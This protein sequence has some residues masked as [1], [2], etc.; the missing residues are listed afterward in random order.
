MAS[1]AQKTQVAVINSRLF[2]NENIATSANSSIGLLSTGAY[3]ASSSTPYIS[4]ATTVKEASELIATKLHVL[5]TTFAPTTYVDQKV[6]D[7]INSAPGILDTLGEIAASLGNDA[8]LSVTLVSTISAETGR[9]TLSEQAL[10]TALISESA[11]AVSSEETLSSIIASETSRAISVEESLSTIIASETSYAR[12]QEQLLST[13]IASESAR[14]ISQEQY[15]STTLHVEIQRALQDDENVSTIFSQEVLR[16]T[17][18]ESVLSTSIVTER[19]RATGAEETLSTIVASEIA[20]AISAEES[21]SSAVVSEISRATA[22]ETTI[23]ENLSTVQR[24]YINKDG[25]VKMTANLDMSGSKIVNLSSSPVDS[26]DAVSLGYYK[27][28]ATLNYEGTISVAPYTINSVLNPTNLDLITSSAGAILRVMG[29]TSSQNTGTVVY[30]VLSTTSTVTANN[31]GEYRRIVYPSLNTTNILNDAGILDLSANN[32]D[33]SGSSY[34]NPYDLTTSGNDLRTKYPAYAIFRI[35]L[36]SRSRFYIY[37]D[38]NTGSMI[39]IRMDPGDIFEFGGNG[40]YFRIIYRAAIDAATGGSFNFD[41]ANRPNFTNYV[42]QNAFY[43]QFTTGGTITANFR[44]IVVVKNS[45]L[46]LKT[47]NSTQWEHIDT[48]DPY[49]QGTKNRIQIVGNGP[50]ISDYIIDIAPDYI[51]Q[52][53]IRTVGDI[54]SGNW[55][56]NPIAAGRG[57]TGQT[58]YSNGDILYGDMGTL[59]KL[60]IG[61]NQKVIK[62]INGK[63]SWQDNTTQ[64]IIMTTNINGPSKL[65]ATLE[66]LS[67][68]V[69]VETTR[70]TTVETTLSTTIVNQISSII[71][72][73]PQALD[74]LNEIAIALGNDPNLSATLIS[75]I[76]GETARATSAEGTLTANLSFEISRASAAEGFISTFLISTITAERERA[77]AAEAS[78][79]TA[80]NSNNDTEM[81]RAVA[82]E[83]GLSTSIAEEIARA[84]AAESGLDTDI[85]NEIARATEIE[86][87]LSTILMQTI[88]DLSTE[89]SRATAAEQ[90]ISSNLASEISRATGIE[91]GHNGRI[92]TIEH[93]INTGAEGDVLKLI[94]GVP[95]LAINDTTG[96]S[97]SDATNF[98]TLTTLQGALDYLFNFTQTRK[99]IQHVVAS[100]TDYSDPATA[101]AGFAAG[102]VHFIN[103]DASNTEI[104][105]PKVA[106]GVSYPDG[107]VY[108]IVHNGDYTTNNYTVK[109]AN[110]TT[111]TTVN[112]LEL[113]PRDTISLIWDSATSSY[114]AGVGL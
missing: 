36:T 41:F 57:G 37:I 47:P 17:G 3:V 75:T 32:T 90:G 73:A 38:A 84:I 13:I 97:I 15:L 14:A 35:P 19:I 89:T 79:S 45:D 43:T 110:Y 103:Y 78:I 1:S 4:S 100:S 30:T 56:A 20:R 60:Q 27:N 114:L 42:Q 70:A 61:T 48:S 92:S 58:G 66:L 99:I 77:L 91:G 34:A 7:L 55:N 24:T 94:G 85:N 52:N 46:L 28:M 51:G 98:S 2:V 8:N 67:T 88:S 6:A 83:Q 95:T 74:T 111:S 108:R 40:T 106:S 22:A 23:T 104:Y 87:G 26:G 5:E 50:Q 16:A 12:A 71:S 86:Q 31:P 107:T 44:K 112:V 102:K 93:Y 96:V 65:Q 72:A 113:A 76:G 21:I 10:S 105:L 109:Y 59:Q 68:S 69:G 81:L 101:N 62:S 82:A 63:P 54:T 9:A 18:V 11:R 39:T 29:Q 64:E 33:G 53:S 25:S 80:S 49:L